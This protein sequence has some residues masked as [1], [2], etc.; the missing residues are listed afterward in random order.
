MTILPNRGADLFGRLEVR[1]ANSEQT[2]ID[3]LPSVS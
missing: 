3:L 1:P 2:H